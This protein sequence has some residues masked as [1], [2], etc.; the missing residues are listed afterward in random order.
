MNI[1]IVDDR[2]ENRYLLEALLK[3]NGHESAVGRKR[4]RGLGTAESRRL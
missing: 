4:R 3:G 2:D 1:L